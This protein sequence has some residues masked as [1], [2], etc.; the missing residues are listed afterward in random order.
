MRYGRSVESYFL[1]RARATLPPRAQPLGSRGATNS[2]LNVTPTLREVAEAQG[3]GWQPGGL[4]YF[5][6]PIARRYHARASACGA[7]VALE[8]LRT[9]GDQMR[10]A[11]EHG[12]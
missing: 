7:T 4:I 3:L 9:G 11:A 5:N 2:T 1:T 8:A 12:G 10:Q 6:K